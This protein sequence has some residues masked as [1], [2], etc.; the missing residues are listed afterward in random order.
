[1]SPDDAAAVFAEAGVADH[2]HA[3]KAEAHALPF[4][5]GHFDAVV[6]I[7]AYEYFGTADNY[8]TGLR[9]GPPSPG[10]RVGGDVAAG[11]GSR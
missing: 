3:I 1:V 5:R 10:V 7:D 11:R 9:P 8:L 6:S 2:V 4:A